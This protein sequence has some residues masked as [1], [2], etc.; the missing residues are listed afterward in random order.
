MLPIGNTPL[1]RLRGLDG[2]GS[3]VYGKAEWVNPSGSVKDRTAWAIFRSAITSGRLRPGMTLIDSSSGNAG[4][5]YAMIGQHLGY[6]VTIYMPASAT[7]ARKALIRSYGAEIVLTDPEAGSDGAYLAVQ[8]AVVSD[9]DFY[10]YADQYGNHANWM[11]HL[12]GTGFEI[13]QQTGGSVT[14]VI[15]GIGTGGTILGVM[16]CL[17]RHN[18]DVAGIGVIPAASRHALPGLRHLPTAMT[19]A[20]WDPTCV[21]AI[22]E[23]DDQAA[24]EMVHRIS[25]T[26]GISIGPSSGA[27]LVVAQQIAARSSGVIVAILPDSGDRYQ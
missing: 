8:K 22:H 5:A 11:A 25:E 14:H 19:P 12:L 9:P 17:R 26:E 18:P 15:A 20:I 24:R 21:D 7:E 6:P 3:T 16:D 23:V 10:F 27:A 1:L 2:P 4:I 13:W